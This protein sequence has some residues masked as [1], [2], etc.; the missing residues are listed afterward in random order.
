GLGNGFGSGINMTLGADASPNHGR[1]EFLGIWRLI[2]DVGTSAG[3]F[4]LSGMTA[5][6]SLG[7]GIALTGMFGFASAAIFWKWL[8]HARPKA[9]NRESCMGRR[10][11]LLPSC[12]CSTRP[13]RE[14]QARRHVASIP[15]VSEFLDVALVWC[16]RC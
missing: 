7:S 9:G 5:L 15:V 10:R 2:S 11:A 13:S 1:T 6:V 8:P 16:W 3:P 12:Q 4:I 14:L